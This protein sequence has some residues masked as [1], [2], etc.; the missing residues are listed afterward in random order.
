MQG[1]LIWLAQ[2]FQRRPEEFCATEWWLRINPANGYA[3]IYFML[4]HPE[5]IKAKCHATLH[6]NGCPVR[7][8]CGKNTKTQLQAAID[9]AMQDLTK[10]SNA[11]P[12]VCSW[13]NPI[14]F[15][16]VDHHFVHRV[17]VTIHVHSWLHEKL[18]GCRDLVTKVPMS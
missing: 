10:V 9:R 17:I 16:T 13:S 3:G 15:D 18:H 12:N 6:I 14:A 7:P 2:F 1:P 4:V 11:R 8:E 5:G